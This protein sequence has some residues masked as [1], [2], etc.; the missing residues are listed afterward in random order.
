MDLEYSVVVMSLWDSGICYSKGKDKL[1]LSKLQDYA[2]YVLSKVIQRAHDDCE[3]QSE[4]DKN[5]CPH[6]QEIFVGLY[7]L[8]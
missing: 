5:E 2:I 7:V 3:L 1:I 8:Y 4:K 6:L